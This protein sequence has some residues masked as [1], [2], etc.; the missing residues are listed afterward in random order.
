MIH[1]DFVIKLKETIFQKNNILNKITKKLFKLC[2]KL[3]ENWDKDYKDDKLK[4]HFVLLNEE[5]DGWL[6]LLD[7]YYR[8][9]IKII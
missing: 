9:V 5:L 3:N 2:S 6:K 7:I 1:N 8:A 4:S